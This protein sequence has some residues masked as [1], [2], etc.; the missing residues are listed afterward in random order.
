M[1]GPRSLGTKNKILKAL[2][3]EPKTFTE[4]KKETGISKPTLNNHLKK[5]VGNQVKKER[6]PE[7]GRKRIYRFDK[8][9]E[10]PAAALLNYLNENLEEPL[11]KEKKETKKIQKLVTPEVVELAED[12]LDKFGTEEPEEGSEILYTI[13]G[14]Q[15]EKKLK[16]DVWT[17]ES[18]K[19]VS[20][21]NMI[22]N[23]AKKKLSELSQEGKLEPLTE[24]LQEDFLHLM[25]MIE[26]RNLL[27][28]FSKLE[29]VLSEIITENKFL[30]Q[31]AES[32]RQK[33]V[34][35]ITTQVFIKLFKNQ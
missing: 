1:E 25:P 22:N 24:K 17:E 20:K 32:E 26:E 11:Y 28:N 3:K 13:W 35:S 5:L 10:G 18:F 30:S 19:G 9:E 8:V 12:F 4:L 14:Y 2:K 31:K 29:S 34:G 21:S 15:A 23:N 33:Y 27:D 16:E 7:D 6:D